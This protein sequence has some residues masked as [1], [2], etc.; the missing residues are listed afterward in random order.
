MIAPGLELFI[1]VNLKVELKVKCLF[2]FE[3]ASFYNPSS[4]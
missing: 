3:M 1:T 4:N 2:L